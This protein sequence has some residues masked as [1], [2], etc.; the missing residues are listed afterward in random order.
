MQQ[1]G[2]VGGSSKSNA[3]LEGMHT[4]WHPLHELLSVPSG[5][6]AEHFHR[7]VGAEGN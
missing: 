6:Q 4:S 2:G 5:D 7:H 1:I 3:A